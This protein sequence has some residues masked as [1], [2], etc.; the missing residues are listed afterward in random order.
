L[1]LTQRIAA[2]EASTKVAS[3]A[4]RDSASMPSAPDPAKR[5]RTRAPST[6]APSTEKSAS[7]T[8]SLVG[9]VSSPVGG[10]QAAPAVGPGDHPHAGIGSETSV[11]KLIRSASSSGRVLGSGQLG[12]GFK[13]PRRLQARAFEQ[14]D[15]RG[16]VR[17]AELGDAGLP[18]AQH[19]ALT[20]QLE[21]DL[22]ELEAVAVL[23]EGAQ[24]RGLP[25][26][27]EQAQRLVRPAPDAP[28]QLMQL[29]NPVALG[30]L[31]EHH[32]GVGD[33]DS[34][35]D[36]GGGHQH[37]ADRRRTPASRPASRAPAAG[38]AAARRRSRA[39]RPCAGARTRR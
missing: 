12:I 26:T 29:R 10:A 7:R 37:V 35:L 1:A 21:V 22:G 2:S 6:S 16:H 8:R 5:S 33:I 38:R 19:L 20:A 17:E 34:H 4:P 13:H 27:E 28:A 23:G 18:R 39:A 14:V 11:P 3:S 36:D 24:A 25:R 31:D 9:R 15:V 30:V 32:R